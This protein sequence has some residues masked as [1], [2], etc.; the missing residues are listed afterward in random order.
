MELTVGCGSVGEVGPGLRRF[1]LAGKVIKGRG[2]GGEPVR[3]V[4]VEEVHRAVELGE[5]QLLDRRANAE[6]LFGRFA[7][8]AR[9]A[10]FQSWVNGPAGQRL[11]LAAI[12]QEPVNPRMLRRTLAVELAYR[13]GGLLAAKI[14]LKHISVATTEGYAARAPARS[15]PSSPAWTGSPPSRGKPRRRRRWPATRSCATCCPSGPKCCTWGRRTTAGSS[16]RPARC[17]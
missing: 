13:P 4:V 8:D 6:S 10:T 11:G 3:W 5:E 7:F 14:H 17:A 16:T 9:Y 1:R 15:L 2:L 12:P